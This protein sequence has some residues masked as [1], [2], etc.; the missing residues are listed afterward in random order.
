MTILEKA[1]AQR[2][3]VMEAEH[4]MND[5]TGLDLYDC[6][7]PKIKEHRR[8]KLLPDA[9]FSV[10]D[11][12]AQLKVRQYEAELEKKR[13]PRLV[14][15]NADLQG[16]CKAYENELEVVNWY[17]EVMEEGLDTRD[18]VGQFHALKKQHRKLQKSTKSEI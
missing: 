4:A 14:Q 15:A 10:A 9:K 3:P 17:L 18:M 11:F 6:L 7:I 16:K 2:T 8:F 12:N 1:L 5:R 13:L